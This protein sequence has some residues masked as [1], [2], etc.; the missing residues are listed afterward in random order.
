MLHTGVYLDQ[1]RHSAIAVRVKD[2]KVVYLTMN[3]TKPV[4][5]KGRTSFEVT[6]CRVS[7]CTLSD[8]EFTRQFELYLPDY[9]VL[10]AAKTYWRSGLEVTPEAK[11]VLQLLLVNNV[12]RKAASV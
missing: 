1:H 12:T 2:G 9:P 8:T 11:K 6:G 7:L 3:P 5:E 10:K 4:V